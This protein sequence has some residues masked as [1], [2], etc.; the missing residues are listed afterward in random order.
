MTIERKE[1]IAEF[2]DSLM[3]I[4]PEHIDNAEM[5]VIICTMLDGYDFTFRNVIDL[6]T[7]VTLLY[8]HARKEIDEP[9]PA[10]EMMLNKGKIH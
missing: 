3:E 4:V 2:V 7:E 1:V 6:C 9:S 8:S 5:A 10:L